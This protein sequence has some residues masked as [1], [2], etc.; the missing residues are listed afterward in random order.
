MPANELIC[1]ACSSRVKR[2]ASLRDGELFECPMCATEFRVGGG[3]GKITTQRAAR[4]RLDE[5]EEID[6]DAGEELEVL[7]DEARPGRRTKRKRRKSQVVELGRWISL[8][9]THW[10]PMVP[11]S[12]GFFVLFILADILVGFVV[13]FLGSFLIRALP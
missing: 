3:A 5:L 7:D 11:P 1:P 13:G 9:F 2:P 10:M 6:E 12:F 8:G 4:P